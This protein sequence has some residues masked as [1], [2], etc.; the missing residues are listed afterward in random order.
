MAIRII[1]NKFLLALIRTLESVL[2][3]YET[4]FRLREFENVNIQIPTLNKYIKSNQN[5][6]IMETNA[7]KKPLIYLLFII[8]IIVIITATTTIVGKKDT[9]TKYFLSSQKTNLKYLSLI[10]CFIV[11]LF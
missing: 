3:S 2:D 11:L 7:L 8:I 6:F 4:S 9:K 1:Y 5:K 10:N